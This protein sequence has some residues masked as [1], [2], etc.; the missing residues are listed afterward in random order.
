MDQLT[1]VPHLIALSVA[2]ALAFPIAWNRE[3]ESRSAGLR[4]FPRRWTSYRLSRTGWLRP[5]HALASQDEGVELVSMR[6]G[7]GLR[8]RWYAVVRVKE[9]LP[10]QQ[11]AGH[12]KQPVGDTA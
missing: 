12:P 5:R 1:F 10:L 8:L 4:T 2:Y 9:N 7:S 6:E 3:S 11:H